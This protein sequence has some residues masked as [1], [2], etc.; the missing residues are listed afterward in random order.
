MVE[1]LLLICFGFKYVICDEYD[2]FPA[3]FSKPPV[4]SSSSAFGI[5]FDLYWIVLF[6]QGCQVFYGFCRI[7]ISM[8]PTKTMEVG[9]C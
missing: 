5:Q 6:K 7:H 9:I 2:G 3:W 1:G 8:C 4:S